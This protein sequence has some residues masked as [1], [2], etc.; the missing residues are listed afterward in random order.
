MATSTTSHPGTKRDSSPPTQVR[1]RPSI[2]GSYADI[3][4][5]DL[6][7][8]DEDPITYFL[9][10]AH[11]AY[12]DDDDTMDFE[13][14]FDA[15]IEDAKHPPLIVRSVSPSSLGSLSLPPPRIPTPP[16]RSESP[17]VDRD[18]PLTP[19]DN[20]TYI[21]LAAPSRPLPFGLPFSLRDFTASKSKFSEKQ[22]SG[23]ADALLSLASVHAMRNPNQGRPKVR[24]GARS[25]RTLQGVSRRGR[26][27]TLSSRRS[28]HAWREP[29][30]DVWSIEEETEQELNSEMG[31]SSV[32]GD[33][34]AF[35]KNEGIDIPAAKPKK[36]VRFV[37]PV[38]DEY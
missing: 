27:R 12:D 37:L 23:S 25:S 34:G 6:S 17:E 3:A 28:P 7:K 21:H 33:L 11:P 16:R 19:E 15:G 35:T 32:E 26:S 38:E 31:D 29:S 1:L 5:L 8:I 18:I 22:G 14:D 13:M 30:P 24:P 20:E 2:E 10:P 36:K 4:D 9:T